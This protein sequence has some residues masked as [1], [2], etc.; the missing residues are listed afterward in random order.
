MY[1]SGLLIALMTFVIIGIFHPVVIKTEYYSGTRWWWLFLLAGLLCLG[2][3]LFIENIT[4]SALTGVLGATL[5]W[6]V[7]ELFSQRRRVLKGWFP[8]NPRR[9]QEYPELQQP[10]KTPKLQA[11]TPEPRPEQER[12]P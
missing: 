12:R 6:S 11:G 5:L 1:F 2:A 10:P 9:I 7:G 3:A 4:L 8:V